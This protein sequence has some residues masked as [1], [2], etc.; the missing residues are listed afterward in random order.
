MASV[1]LIAG[2][3]G[4]STNT[5]SGA[6]TDMSRS[7]SPRAHPMPKVS[8]RVRPSIRV[9]PVASSVLMQCNI[10]GPTQLRGGVLLSGESNHSYRARHPTAFHGTP[11]E[12]AAKV[13]G[14]C[15]HPAPQSEL[16]KAAVLQDGGQQQTSEISG[17]GIPL[18]RQSLHQD[19]LSGN[20]CEAHE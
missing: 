13:G 14:H 15:P 7:I 9:V 2:V 12:I 16:S 8:T 17:P 6:Y 10:H 20:Q 4:V 5:A 3:K 11:G 19:C 18:E 1:P